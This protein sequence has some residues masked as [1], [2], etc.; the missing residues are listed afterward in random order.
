MIES[1]YQFT[2]K[3]FIALPDEDVA[4][5]L[6]EGQAVLKRKMAPKFFY[7]AMQKALLVLLEQW[8]QQLGQVDPE[9]GVILQRQAK[10]WV[11]TPELT[12]IS[13]EHLSPDWMLDEACPVPPELVIEIISPG[14]IFQEL[15]SKAANY[16]EAGVLRVWV[17]DTQA[18]SIAVFLLMH[19]LK[20]TQQP[21]P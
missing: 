6:I 8:C 15:A 2:L 19:R 14:R 3:E 21:Y 20:S 10:D 4:C 7:S 17:V 13:Y 9:W 11:F 12:Y 1:K 5:E 16:L 18:R